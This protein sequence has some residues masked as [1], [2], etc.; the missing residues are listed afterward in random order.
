MFCSEA[1]KWL[2]ATPSNVAVLYTDIKNEKLLVRERGDSSMRLLSEVGTG[3]C[4][5]FPPS[6]YADLHVCSRSSEHVQHGGMSL[7]SEWE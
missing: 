1:S 2:R 6:P 4:C 7:R 5:L 3:P